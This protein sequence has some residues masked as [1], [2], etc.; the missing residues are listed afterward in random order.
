MVKRNGNQIMIL[1]NAEKMKR[2][3]VL[4][5]T[6]DEAKDI[7]DKAGALAAYRKQSRE[8]LEMQNVA[9]EIRLRAERKIGEFSKEIPTAQFKG[10]R[11]VSSGRDVPTTKTHFLRSAGITQHKR[12]EIIAS[13]PDEIF[14]QY[15]EEMKA[16]NG[17]ITTV[18]VLQLAKE[19]QRKAEFAAVKGVYDAVV[20]SESMPLNSVEDFVGNIFNEDCLKT[21]AR[22]PEECIDLVV[23]SCPYDSLRE[24]NGYDFDFHSI[25]QELYRIMKKGGVVVWIVGDSTGA[26]GESGTSFRQALY[27]K[28]VC[29][30]NLHDTMIYQKSA[31]SYPAS[32]RYHQVFEYCFILSRGKPKAVNLLRDRKNKWPGTWGMSS[33]RQVNGKFVQGGKI[34]YEEFG[35]RFNIWRINNGYNFSTKDKE[36]HSHP[37]IF[38]EELARD[39][40]LSWSNPGDIVYDPLLG[41][42]TTMKMAELTGRYSFGSEVS[43]E[44]CGIAGGRLVKHLPA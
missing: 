9:A 3:I 12:Y 44:Y 21:M 2:S 29:G 5:Q 28:D 4:C 41:S 34:K 30:F 16:A 22:L 20:N 33:S 23:T 39:M 1:D 37:A 6:I 24:Y 13:L 18:G 10:L 43:K 42:G 38:P 35:I 36:A 7:R 32:T 31:P 27:F 40:I 25:A 8:S 11:N 14:D 17:E 26:N 19:F 15:I